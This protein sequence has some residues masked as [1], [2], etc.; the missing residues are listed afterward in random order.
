MNR[1]QRRA[2]D[3]QIGKENTERLA[4][5]VSLF[6]KMPKKCDACQKDFDKTDKDMVL[7]WNVVVKQEVVRLFCPECIKK[8]KE[9]ID[10]STENR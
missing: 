10:A 9:L 1:K 8:T 5:Q 6:N 3:K 4:E 2:Y 7:S